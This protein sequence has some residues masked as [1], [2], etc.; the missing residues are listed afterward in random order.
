MDIDIQ[1]TIH[2]ARTQRRLYLTPSEHVSYLGYGLG[3]LIG[4]VYFLYD[5]VLDFLFT[6][7]FF[8]P[9]AKEITGMIAAALFVIYVIVRRSTR[10]FEVINTTLPKGELVGLFREL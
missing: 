10:R 6:G 7:G 8:D 3:L 2:K 9:E 1:K 5:Y 4:A